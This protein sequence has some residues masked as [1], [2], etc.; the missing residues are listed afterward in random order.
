MN[1]F[2]L[3]GNITKTPE[4]RVSKNGENKYTFVT[5]AINGKEKTDYLDVTIFGKTAE[6]IVQ[7]CE[8]GCPLTVQGYMKQ[9]TKDNNYRITLVASKVFFGF[10]KEK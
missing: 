3:A 5:I 7:Y 2:I 8:K 10:R 9:G 4:I 1:E 6:T